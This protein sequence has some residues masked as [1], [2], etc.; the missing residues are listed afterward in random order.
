MVH[1]RMIQNQFQILTC[2]FRGVVS[3][4]LSKFS[5]S[6]KSE[7]LPWYLNKDALLSSGRTNRALLPTFFLISSKK[8]TAFLISTL[9]AIV[10]ASETFVYGTFEKYLPYHRHNHVLDQTQLESNVLSAPS[11][12]QLW[13]LVT[14]SSVVWCF[15]SVAIKS[16]TSARRILLTS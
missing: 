8:K 9:V 14:F 11:H 12:P 13:N 5:K 6:K 3:T 7:L 15:V 1:V 4:L 10:D 2:M 16:L